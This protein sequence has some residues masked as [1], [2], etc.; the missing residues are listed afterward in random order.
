MLEQKLSQIQGLRQEQV[1]TPQQIMSLDILQAT[2]LQLQQKINQELAENPTLEQVAGGNE[3]LIGDPME[4]CDASP[5]SK[6]DI[7][8][9]MAERDEDLASIIQLYD[10]WKDYSS[11][12]SVHYN[13]DADEK[14]QFFM[15]SLVSEKSL[16]EYLQEQLRT[17]N[18]SEKLKRIAG[19]II[20]SID[21]T[22]YLRTHLADIAIISDADMKDVKKTLKIVHTFDPPGIGASDLR[23]NLLLQLERRDMKKSLEYKLVLNYLPLVR[24]NHIPKIAAKMKLTT[25]QIYQLLKKLKKLNPFPASL[26]KIPQPLTDYVSP[27]LEI[28]KENGEYKIFL[29]KNTS[30]RLRISS[31]YM[32]LLEKKEIS[33]ETREYIKAKILKSKMLIKSLD[34]R[35]TTI[36]KIAEIILQKQKDFFHQGVENL[37]PLTMTQ[38]AKKI[39]VHETTVSRAIKG[40][41][42]QTPRGLYDFRFFFSGGYEA[43]DGEKIASTSIKEKISDIVDNESS[44]KPLSDNKISEKLKELG[45]DVARRTITKYREELN[46]PSSNMRRKWK[47]QK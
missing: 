30:P 9:D 28:K 27:E 34:Q 14:H 46:I 38:V 47:R 4:D 31:Y 20:G 32:K 16:Q 39:E 35:K 43:N 13:S 24:K 26:H 25:T 15:R 10:N 37:H 40:K 6:S 8:A 19:N 44:S 11:D 42:L 23:E 7:A 41:H 5:D 18:L 3:D 21:D 17:S 1:M 12:K 36:Y 29:Q 22:G 45:Y 2:I 33:K